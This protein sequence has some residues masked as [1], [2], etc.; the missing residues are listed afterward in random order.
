M[1]MA[2]LDVL[3]TDPNSHVYMAESCKDDTI[4]PEFIA[5]ADYLAPSAKRSLEFVH[6]ILPE[7]FHE[8][9]RGP[10]LADVS[11]NLR[12]RPRYDGW[13]QLCGRRQPTASSKHTS[14][15][16]HR[17]I[18]NNGHLRRKNHCSILRWDIVHRLDCKL[19][20]PQAFPSD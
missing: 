13:V 2:V 5:P 20:F 1:D 8:H 10:F 18:V 7:W 4:L 6:E 19:T 17:R 15:S 12:K 16:I 14:S 11:Q 9:G 3:G